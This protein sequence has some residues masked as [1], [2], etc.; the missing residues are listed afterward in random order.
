MD[1]TILMM[2]PGAAMSLKNVPTSMR[3]AAAISARLKRGRL[4]ICLA[5]GRVLRSEGREAGPHGEI[6][7]KDPTFARRVLARGDI[8][9][10][11]AYMDG[12]FETPDLTAVLEYF[13]CNFEDA[14][15]LGEGNAFSQ[16]AN[17]IRHGLK[18]N[19]KRGSK[20]N[21][22]AHYD[23][24]NAF[25]SRWL[26]PSMTYSSARFETPDQALE[27]AQLTKYRAIAQHLE[28]KEG[29]RVLEI[30]SGWGGFAEVAAKHYGAHVTGVTISDAQYAFAKQRIFEAGLADRVDIQL[31]DYRDVEGRFDGVA[32]IEMFEA[33]GERYWP[34]YFSKVADVLEP[35][36]RAALQ[37]ITIDDNLFEN[38]RARPDFIQRYIFPGGMLPSIERLGR[39]A[40]RAGLALSPPDTF[41]QSY[42]R[43]LAE[44][45]QRFHDAWEDIRTLGFDERFR[46][47]WT[48]Y[49]AYCE[50]GFKTGRIDVG[51]FVLQKP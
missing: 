39:E 48:Y 26:D 4:D 20:R 32:S 1:K 16:L 22:L 41:G 50:A 36:G 28:L 11:E 37:V 6:V 25:Y 29:A 31:K 45:R 35:G 14:G 18:R 12:Q 24:G 43:T 13:T 47:L 9:F 7:V 15:P 17:T 27:E 40:R 38:Y 23:L 34:T 42:A 3:L 30:G 49:F 44:W 19:S 51:H 21:I 33:V 2:T 5:D 8:G 46:R 10:A